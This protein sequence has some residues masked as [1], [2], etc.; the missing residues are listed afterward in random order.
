ML[1]H[2]C[3]WKKK[4]QIQTKAENADCDIVSKLAHYVYFKILVFNSLILS[5][6]SVILVFREQ[7][8]TATTYFLL[9]TET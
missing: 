7:E 8:V 4:Y 9:R 6:F 5:L 1:A 3:L 2:D